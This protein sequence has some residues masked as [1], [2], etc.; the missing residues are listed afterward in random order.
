[1]LERLWTSGRWPWRAARVAL[2]PFA[3]LFAGVVAIRNLLY[4]HGLLAVRRAAV[5]VVSVGNLRVGGS[6]KTPF[7]IWLVDGLRA[8]GLSVAVVARG[9]G[10]PRGLVVVGSKSDVG[11]V[12]DVAGARRVVVDGEPADASP[13]AAD[14]ALLVAMRTRTPVVTSPDR[15]KA[16]TLAADRFHPDVVVLDDGFQHRALARDL[17]IVLVGA[18]DP[19][20]ALLPAGALREPLHALTRAGLVLWEAHGTRDTDW[21]FERR[22]TGLVRSPSDACVS[23]TTDAL[24]GATVAAV[25]GIARNDSFLAMLRGMD[26]ELRAVCT[27]PDHHRYDEKDWLEISRRAPDCRWIITTEKDLVKLSALSGGDPRLVA[28]R[29]DLAITRADELLDTVLARL[30]LDAK[31]RG[32]HDRPLPRGSDA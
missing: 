30:R 2:R 26:A 25:C 19:A 18:D 10:A 24:R 9:Y 15:A 8:R 28:L 23:A 17:D 16:C 31:R 7:V 22:A 11:K 20:Q 32:Q 1:M 29:I 6:G 4:D 12:D 5:P 27:Y 14:E 13:A 21:S 3:L